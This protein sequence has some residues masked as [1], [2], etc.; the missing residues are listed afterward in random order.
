MRIKEQPE[1]NF[2]GKKILLKQ[3]LVLE[4]IKK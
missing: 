3:T 1:I 4:T 2:S